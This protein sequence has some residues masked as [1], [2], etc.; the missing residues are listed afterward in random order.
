MVLGLIE[1]GPG[2][3]ENDVGIA[4][5]RPERKVICL[6]GDGSML[7]TLGTLATIVDTGAP[8]LVLIVSD[9]GCFEV[10]GNQ[11]VAGAGRV[12]H[13][14][15]AEAAGFRNVFRFEDART[16]AEAVPD[17]LSLMGP[18]FVHALLKPGNETPIT[19]SDGEDSAYLRTSLA[20][21]ARTVREV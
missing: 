11:P 18:T 1:L 20:E 15:L 8:N 12:D 19:R 13:A 7:M 10:T 16:Y 17:V 5:A 21:A 6:N 3:E 14:A 2:H 4:L 9:N